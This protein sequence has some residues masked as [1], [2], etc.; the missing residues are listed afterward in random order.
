MTDATINSEKGEQQKP[1]RILLFFLDG[2]A[3]KT[4]GEYLCP[5]IPYIGI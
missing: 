4:S 3:Y 2:Y 1:K 5:G